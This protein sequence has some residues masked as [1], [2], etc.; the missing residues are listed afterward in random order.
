M[1]HMPGVLTQCV[2]NKTL[3]RVESKDNVPRLIDMNTEPH[4]VCVCTH[5]LSWHASVRVAG[6]QPCNI[7]EC[8]C[9]LYRPVVTAEHAKSYAEGSAKSLAAL[10]EL[11]KKK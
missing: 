5:P 9:S 11:E 7:L 6:A 3:I 2:K 10:D 8:S 1:T 4:E